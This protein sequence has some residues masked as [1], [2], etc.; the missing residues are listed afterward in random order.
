[1]F[2]VFEGWCLDWESCDGDCYVSYY[3]Y[4]FSVDGLD[5]NVWIMQKC[6]VNVVKSW[7]FVFVDKVIMFG[8][9]GKDDMVVVIFC[10]DYKSNNFN[11]MMMKCQYWKK[12]DGCWKIV[13]EGVV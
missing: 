1:M 8:Y 13:Y 4:N 5:Y 10:Q 9:L 2:S 6:V 3:L 7:I 12:E 11:N